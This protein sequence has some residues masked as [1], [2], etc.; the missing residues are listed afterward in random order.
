MQEFLLLC[1]RRELFSETDINAEDSFAY[2]NPI[3]ICLEL[4]WLVFE[5]FPD[6]L[7]L[8]DSP[9]T[10]EQLCAEELVKKLLAIKSEYEVVEIEC[11]DDDC[12]GKLLNNYVCLSMMCREEFV[13]VQIIAINRNMSVLM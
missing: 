8:V 13:D 2:A 11:V 4:F 1:C 7:G 9:N 6:Y 12:E 10:I 5:A 3:T